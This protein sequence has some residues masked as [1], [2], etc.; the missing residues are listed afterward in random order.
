MEIPYPI[1]TLHAV[2]RNV[3]SEIGIYL[4]I[5][6]TPD[7]TSVSNTDNHD[8]DDLVEITVLPAPGNGQSTD[9]IM[10]RDLFKALSDCAALHPG[11]VSSDDDDEDRI[12]FEEAEYQSNL[13]EFLGEGGWITAENVDQFRFDDADEPTGTILGPGAGITR[14]W[15]EGGSI[16]NGVDD[17][18]IDD[19]EYQETKWR[20]TG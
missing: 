2:K 8:D 18:A 20:R 15:E 7:V 9:E 16:K 3:A 5:S 17:V 1:L 12:I 10:T 13:E 11:P 6:L 14:S 19:K 4:Q